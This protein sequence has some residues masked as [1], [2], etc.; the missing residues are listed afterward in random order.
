MRLHVKFRGFPEWLHSNRVAFV[1]SAC[2]FLFCMSFAQQSSFAQSP[3]AHPAVS[4]AE[5]APSV[6][7]PTLKSSS[8]LVLVPTVVRD[9]QGKPLAGLTK[10]AFRLEEN[11]KPQTI[12][13][14]EEVHASDGDSP[15]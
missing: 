3:D 5:Q 1:S 8:N 9:R 2:V 15:G 11:G 12:S 13:L 7:V 10:D 14:F 6:D 4:T